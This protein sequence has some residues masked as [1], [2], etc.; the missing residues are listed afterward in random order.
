[1]NAKLN[2]NYIE[3]A[4]NPKEDSLPKWLSSPTVVKQIVKGRKCN[5]FH[6]RLLLANTGS[7]L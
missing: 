3:K 1:M 5:A 2:S 4:E 7:G 6:S